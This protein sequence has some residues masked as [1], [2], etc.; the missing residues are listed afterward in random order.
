M[1]LR[2]KNYKQLNKKQKAKVDKTF[3]RMKK[4]RE[5]DSVRLRQ[6]IKDKLSWALKEQKKGL[7]AIERFKKS[8]Q[9][10]SR[11]LLKLEGIILC[12]SQILEET[13][14]RNIKENK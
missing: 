8:I 5:K 7:E 6:S 2:G 1:T 10:N 4:L 12:L 14:K 13:Y 11:E 3:K 9:I